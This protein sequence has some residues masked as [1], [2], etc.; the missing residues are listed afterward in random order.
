MALTVVYSN[1]FGGVFA[2][3][4][5]GTVSNYVPDSLGSTIG[6]TSS[7]GSL[8]D[9]W[10][11][12]PYG[13]FARHSGSSVTPLTFLGVLGYFQDV[14]SQF[15]YVR[16]RHL[17]VDLARWLTLDP[18]WPHAQAYAYVNA[19][20]VSRSDRT[21]LY[22]C[23]TGCNN[24]SKK[25]I[26]TYCQWCRVN[27]FE[28]SCMGTCNSMIQA[29]EGN[30]NPPPPPPPPSICKVMPPYCQL[31]VN[32]YNNSFASPGNAT[33]GWAGNC[34]ICAEE[35]GLTG[36]GGDGGE[37]WGCYK[38]ELPGVPIDA[39]NALDQFLELFCEWTGG[40]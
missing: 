17:R 34:M 37:A 5:G 32:G 24:S 26:S 29:Y 4:R 33:T 10:E 28:S 2:E 7:A 38:G 27:G 15:F 1:A 30:C 40:E 23:T 13:E 12:W 16:A 18:I 19:R 25:C 35:M 22:P 3:N 9:R 36:I 21:G 14:L 11:Y 8:T 31:I 6:L 20:P 39:E